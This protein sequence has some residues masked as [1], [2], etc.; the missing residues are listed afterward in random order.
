MA[1]IKLLERFKSSLKYQLLLGFCYHWSISYFHPYQQS[2]KS[3]RTEWRD[4]QTTST[5]LAKNKCSQCTRTIVPNSSIQHIA[6]TM[7]VIY[8]QRRALSTLHTSIEDCLD[9]NLLN[10]PPP[11]VKLAPLHWLIMNK[12]CF[13]FNSKAHT[14]AQ[15]RQ[16]HSRSRNSRI[17]DHSRKFVISSFTN[18]YPLTTFHQHQPTAFLFLAISCGQF[19]LSVLWQNV[20]VVVKIG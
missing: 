18:S 3:L 5:G 13:Y 11:F 14:F 6:H 12:T 19:V 17:C 8:T 20:L 2:V 9:L 7:A 15:Q 4:F 16:T 1:Q 10:I